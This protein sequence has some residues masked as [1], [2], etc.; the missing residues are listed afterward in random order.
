MTRFASNFSAAPR[1]DPIIYNRVLER[2]LKTNLF[3]KL[4]NRLSA[5]VAVAIVLLRRAKCYYICMNNC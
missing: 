5:V 2:A 1:G 4:I 3:F